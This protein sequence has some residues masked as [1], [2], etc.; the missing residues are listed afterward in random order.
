MMG[1]PFY[2]SKVKL[3][4]IA[5]IVAI[6]ATIVFIFACG[7]DLYAYTITPTATATPTV[8]ATITRTPKPRTAT[9]TATI[10]LTP[11]ITE[12]PTATPTSTSSPTLDATGLSMTLTALPTLESTPPALPASP[13]DARQLLEENGFTCSQPGTTES[14]GYTWACSQQSENQDVEVVFTSETEDTMKLIVAQVS[15]SAPSG[16]GNLLTL[17]FLAHLPFYQVSEVSTGTN[18][19]TPTSIGTTAPGESD[20]QNAINLW[21]EQTYYNLV[22]GEP[23]HIVFEGIPY[24]LLKTGDTYELQ[25][26]F[27]VGS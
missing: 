14:R 22:D 7:L 8:T 25:M 16:D 11:T 6:V 17:I 27:A 20:L 23:V 15:V 13:G 18:T 3:N 19:A 21:V 26:G 4:R 24:T 1:E 2:R 5:L 9:P 10:T 12:T